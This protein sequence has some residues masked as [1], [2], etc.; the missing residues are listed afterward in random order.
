MVNKI[1]VTRAESSAIY[2]LDL[3]SISSKQIYIINDR[4][5]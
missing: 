2:E 3:G 4:Q 1:S 5:A